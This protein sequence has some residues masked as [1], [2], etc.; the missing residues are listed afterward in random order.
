MK[1]FM[2]CLLFLGMTQAR[3][4]DGSDDPNLVNAD[5][6]EAN[7]VVTYFNKGDKLYWWVKAGGLPLVPGGVKDVQ[8]LLQ[9]SGTEKFEKALKLIG[10]S[11][12]QVKETRE[13]IAQ[14]KWEHLY[15]DKA[16]A[17]R[18]AQSFY[19]AMAYGK[20]GDPD[21]MQLRNAVVWAGDKTLSVWRV[22]LSDATILDIPEDCGN[23]ARTYY[24]YKVQLERCG[25]IKHEIVSRE[26]IGDELVFQHRV[27]RERLGSSGELCE[28]RLFETRSP[29]QPKAVDR[30][31]ALGNAIDPCSS[32]DWNG[33]TWQ[34]V[35]LYWPK[36]SKAPKVTLQSILEPNSSFWL[37]GDS[38][39]NQKYAEQAIAVLKSHK[40]S[41]GLK[42]DKKQ[43]Q[44]RRKVQAVIL[45]HNVC[46]KEVQMHVYWEGWHWKE[47]WIG[48]MV[49][50]GIGFPIGWIARGEM[51]VEKNPFFNPG[52]RPT[53]F[54]FNAGARTAVSS[55]QFPPNWADDR[56]LVRSRG[57]MSPAE[58]GEI[59]LHLIQATVGEVKRTMS[60]LELEERLLQESRKR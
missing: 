37:A 30:S 18:S 29:V 17:P 59:A 56:Y 60:L 21:G 13:L 32:S 31:I 42:W 28:E 6:D 23:V 25:S 39:A 15:G 14:G 46:T 4:T 7:E 57:V 26:Q 1:I 33:R 54:Q 58:D 38:E 10:L 12:E 48:K 5:L 41:K 16:I 45:L 40:D 52:T 24:T 8:S 51:L 3:A 11:G 47:Y 22:A 44:F 27:Y 9:F 55:H 34:I 50:F 43:K 19:L 2:F 20:R 49:G 53:T 36:L 35:G